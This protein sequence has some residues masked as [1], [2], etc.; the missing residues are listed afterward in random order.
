MKL[1]ILFKIN[2]YRK[3]MGYTQNFFIF[4]ENFMRRRQ[5]INLVITD[6]SPEHRGRVMTSRRHFNYQ[7]SSWDSRRCSVPGT[8]TVG[9]LARGP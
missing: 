5:G 7:L 9:A 3:T 2:I 8:G 1:Q 6:E 4:N